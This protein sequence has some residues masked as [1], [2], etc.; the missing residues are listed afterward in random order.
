MVIE[1]ELKLPF[2]V[3]ENERE[4]FAEA[5]HDEYVVISKEGIV[6][7]FYKNELDGYFAG[8]AEFGKGNFL[9]QRCV[10]QEEEE[11]VV[12]HSRVR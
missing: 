1:K 2:H 6:H 9:L 5:H 11:K 7:G 3:F 10:R 12:F 8:K 4:K